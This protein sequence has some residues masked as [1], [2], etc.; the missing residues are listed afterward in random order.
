VKPLEARRALRR[1]N[2]LLMLVVGVLVGAMLVAIAKQPAKGNAAASGALN[3]GGSSTQT[4]TAGGVAAGTGTGTGTGTGAGTGLA[5][6]AGTGGSGGAAAA[7]GSSGGGG[8]ASTASNCS[9]IDSSGVQGVTK[10]TIKIGFALPSLGVL[11][12]AVNIGNPQS[13]I[14]A[15]LAGMRKVGRLPVCGRDIAPDFQT[16]NV[17]DPSQSR[18]ACDN[19]AQ[20]GDF[21]VI[22]LFAFSAASCVTQENH[23]FLLDQGTADTLA[24]FAATPLLFTTDPPIDSELRDA[25]YWAVKTGI[26]D[27]KTIGVYSNQNGPGGPDPASALVQ[28]NL[29]DVLAQLGHPVKDVIVSNTSLSSSTPTAAD[30]NDTTAV[31]KFK[32]DNIQV[33]FPLEFSQNFMNQAEAQGYHPQWAVYS[34]GMASDATTSTYPSSLD[35]ALGLLWEQVGEVA[36]GIPPTPQAQACFG[37]YTAAGNGAPPGPDTA[38]GQTLREACDP[39]DLLVRALAAAGNDLTSSTLV[40]GMQTVQNVPESYYSPQT[41]LPAKHW[42]ASQNVAVQWHASCSCWKMAGPFVPLYSQP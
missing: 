37:Y 35:G 21:A 26:V 5:G 39:V 22:S 32:A 11:A 36:S 30:P 40:A 31:E 33:V 8:G 20:N 27:G 28:Q 13:D 15:A 23:M 25:A 2:P 14:N 7:S 34:T 9:G 16:F 19:F 3:G 24:D 12:A 10:T 42:G 29:V 6:E 18:A 17:L 1:A 41:F 4:T 38:A